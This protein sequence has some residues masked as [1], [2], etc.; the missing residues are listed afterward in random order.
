MTSYSYQSF[1]VLAQVLDVNIN[2]NTLANGNIIKYNST[3]GLWDNSSSGPAG[4]TTSNLNDVLTNGNTTTQTIVFQ[5]A[6]NNTLS[7]TGMSSNG[8]IALDAD[9]I[10]LNAINLINLTATNSD[11]TLTA[12]GGAVNMTSNTPQ[13]IT[14]NDGFTVNCSV[15]PIALNAPQMDLFATNNITLTSNTGYVVVGNDGNLGLNTIDFGSAPGGVISFEDSAG[16]NLATP[17]PTGGI[18]YVRAGALRY[19]GSGGTST[20]IALA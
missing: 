17:N 10:D 5:G 3:T 18:L 4:P 1:P 7:S 11:I 6:S 16:P 19:L 2:Q 15:N 12:N 14:A 20:I 9:K 8:N 13:T